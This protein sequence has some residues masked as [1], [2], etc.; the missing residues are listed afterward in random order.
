M[1][2]KISKIQLGMI[3][4]MLMCSMQLGLGDTILLNISK[5][6][7]LIAI[8]IGIIIG[9]IPI[10]IYIKINES[11]IDK[12]IYQKNTILFGNKLG[13]IINLF[14]FLIF[15]IMLMI[16]V[17]SLVL[18]MNS[19]YL[20][21]TPYLFL[22]LLV[23]LTVN[24]ISFCSSEGIARILRIGFIIT[25][26]AMIIIEIFLLRYIDIN[27]IL[28]IIITPNNVNQITNG[29]LYFAC[30]TSLLSFL[31]LTISRTKIKN[32]NINKIIILSYLFG[33]ICLLVTMFFVVSCFGYDM[34]TLFRYPEYIILKKITLSS[35]DLHLE[36]LL[37]F[38]W[39]I[40]II[41]L[42]I[43]ANYGLLCGI[44]TYS[45]NRKINKYII[46]IVS[47]L[48]VIISKY[49]INDVTTSII[50]MKNNY[51]K[52]IALPIFIIYLIIYLKIKKVAKK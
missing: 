45:K 25:F 43:I 2:N 31:L 17:R 44:K 24:V 29:A 14:V 12:N 10:I 16:S 48:A 20:Q 37:A 19:K 36:N 5:N 13:F 22:G 39:N 18:F 7:V 9:L 15:F 50:F 21:D 3:L 35:T 11:L 42:A 49:L 47:L 1:N 41:S 52:L 6:N 27:N 40:Y 46:L 33:T 32:K 30:Q 26:I 28:P 4:S 34:A 51:V 8:T 23:I 38:R